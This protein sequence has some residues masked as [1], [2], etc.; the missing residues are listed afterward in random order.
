[1]EVFT[2]KGHYRQAALPGNFGGGP[3]FGIGRELH[4]GA[5][6]FEGATAGRIAAGAL[7]L[8]WE[9]DMDAAFRIF[10]TNVRLRHLPTSLH[11]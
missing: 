11:K 8:F 2:W 10:D 7:L 3:T 6:Q 1:M 9:I 5:R 4:T